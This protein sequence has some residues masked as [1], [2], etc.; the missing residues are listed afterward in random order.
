MKNRR[1]AKP[2]GRRFTPLASDMYRRLIAPAAYIQGRDVLATPETYHPLGG[3]TAL[4]LG[5]TTALAGTEDAITTG[6]AGADIAVG[7][8]EAGV[9]A[10][11]FDQIDRLVTA[12]ESTGADVV[13]GAGGGVAL[14]TSKAVAQRIGAE[15]AVVPTIASTDAP[16]SSVAVVYESDGSFAGYV[17]RD[18]NP[19]V[20]AV[21]T[22][23]IATAPVRYLRYGMGDAFATRFEAETAAAAHVETMAGGRSTDGGLALARQCYENLAE[24]GSTALAAVANDAVSPAVERII[25]TNVLFSGI[26]FESGGLAAAHAF[27]KGFRAVDADG[28]HGL[29]VGFGTIAQLVLE[30]EPDRL[31]EGLAVAAALE[32]APTLSEF[33]VTDDEVDRMAERACRDDTTMSG[34]PMDVT[35]QMAADA[36]RTADTLIKDRG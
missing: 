1:V 9:D 36:I 26:G 16:C 22:Q 6:L 35:P 18:R 31:E 5:G 27:H 12:A 33:G 21:D 24:Y 25:E 11:T 34:E 2:T 23:V 20:V 7:T 10:C 15:L 28:P 29:L 30:G 17:F 32:I 14:D 4:V 13:V 8:V 3:E 19:E